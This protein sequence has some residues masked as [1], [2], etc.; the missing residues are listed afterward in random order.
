V[1]VSNGTRRPCKGC[2]RPLVFIKDSKTGEIVPLDTQAPVWTIETDMLGE[3]VAVRVDAFVSHFSTCS[4]ANDFS[5]GR[6][7]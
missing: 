7:P 1:K 5:K 4:V 6:R 3:E 2:G